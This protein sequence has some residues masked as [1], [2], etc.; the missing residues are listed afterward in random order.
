V[1]G[2]S[3]FITV[4]SAQVGDQAYDLVLAWQTQT[5]TFEIVEIIRVD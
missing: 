2:F 3:D 1:S 4:R 5:Q